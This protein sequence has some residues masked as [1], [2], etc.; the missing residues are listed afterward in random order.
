ML[1]IPVILSEDRENL[2]YQD[3][4]IFQGVYY[5]IKEMIM[6][7]TVYQFVC[8]FRPRLETEGGDRHKHLPGTYSAVLIAQMIR[9]N[10]H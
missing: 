10:S 2:F 1:E 9:L 6:S 8:F 3:F 4:L 7:E 5:V